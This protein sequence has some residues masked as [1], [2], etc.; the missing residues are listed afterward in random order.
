MSPWQSMPRAAGQPSSDHAQGAEE[1]AAPCAAD[2]MLAERL[3]TSRRNGV[4]CV[5][6]DD[7]YRYW[8]EQPILQTTPPNRAFVLTLARC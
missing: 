7:G 6:S 1:A 5:D 3:A 4:V 8:L 2:A